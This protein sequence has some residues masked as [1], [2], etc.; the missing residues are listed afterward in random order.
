MTL[1]LQPVQIA[2]GRQDS[3]DHRVFT[4]GFHTAVLVKLSDLHEGGAGTWFPE[5]GF[6]L[7]E[8]VIRP[9]SA[10]LDEVPTEIEQPAHAA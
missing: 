6:G 1:R 8:I 9:P 4:D 2:T 3:D 5:A 10:D 7:V